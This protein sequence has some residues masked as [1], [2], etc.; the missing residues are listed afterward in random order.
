MGELEQQNDNLQTRIKELLA[1]LEDTR[2]S[3]SES[4]NDQIK[5]LSSK[6]TLLEA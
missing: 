4:E 6:L 1:E 3:Q 5:S 2:R